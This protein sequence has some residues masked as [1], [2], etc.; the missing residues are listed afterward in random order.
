MLYKIL[1]RCKN[2]DWKQCVHVEW[3]SGLR[4]NWKRW[5]SDNKWRNMRWWGEIVEKRSWDQYNA[6]T[7]AR[8]CISSFESQCSELSNEEWLFRKIKTFVNT[9]HFCS[10]LFRSY[11]SS[12]STTP[13]TFWKALKEETSQGEESV[14]VWSIWF[15]SAWTLP[16]RS[17]V[18]RFPSKSNWR[19]RM[20]IIF[21]GNSF[22]P[23]GSF[24]FISSHF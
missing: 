2:L 5:R 6:G 7:S 18:Q 20:I 4:S 3:I 13:L 16:W 21:F 11:I 12:F 23:V 9:F 8:V 22:D 14:I 19:E 17:L 1:V 24:S 15:S 10:P